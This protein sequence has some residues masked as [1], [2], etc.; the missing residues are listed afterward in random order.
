MKSRLDA[1]RRN[2]YNTHRRE[3]RARCSNVR[4]KDKLHN[5]QEENRELAARLALEEASS[6]SAEAR[7]ERGIREIGHLQDRNASL[8][9]RNTSLSKRVKRAPAQA[10]RAVEKAVKVAVKKVTTLKLKEKGVISDTSRELVRN[11]TYAGVPR[12]KISATISTVVDAAGMSVE[13]SIS[14]R[15]IGR[16]N[17][18]ADVASDLQTMEGMIEADG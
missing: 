13:G 8:E 9:T 6:R 4:L 18:E 14:T 12:D 3:D 16:I 17:L 2:L 5:A 15:S 10:A 1:C 11:L 7:L